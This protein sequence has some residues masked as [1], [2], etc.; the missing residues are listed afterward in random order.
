MDTKES[1]L[2]GKIFRPSQRLSEASYPKEAK[3]TFPSSTDKTATTVMQVILSSLQF[4]MFANS[5]LTSL[6]YH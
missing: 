2:R 1:I 3:D 6:F 5:A 4:W